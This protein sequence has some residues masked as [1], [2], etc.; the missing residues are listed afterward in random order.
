MLI[1]CSLSDTYSSLF[2]HQQVRGGGEVEGEDDD[3]WVRFLPH[4]LRGQGSDWEA[5]EGLL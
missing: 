2:L 5:V 4:K 1:R 3:G